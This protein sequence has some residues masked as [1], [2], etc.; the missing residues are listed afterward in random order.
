MNTPQYC[1]IYLL[2]CLM[3]SWLLHV[4]NHEFN[5]CSH[6]KINRNEIE[7]KF[8]IKTHVNV[9]Y[10]LPEDCWK[11]F[12]T[13]WE[14]N[15]WNTEQWTTFCMRKFGTIGSTERIAVSGRP[16]CAIF[17]VVETAYGWSDTVYACLVEYSFLFPPVQKLSK[18]II[19][20]HSY[21]PVSYTH[22]TLPTN[23]EV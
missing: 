12:L 15:E 7:D 2:N 1:L 22:L 20:Y 18:A 5:F 16:F 9:K 17:S 8:L 4:A 6:V 13:S 3:T 21:S 11:N 14:R 10:F 23:R 19:N